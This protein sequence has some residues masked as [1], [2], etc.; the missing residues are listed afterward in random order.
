MSSEDSLFAVIPAIIEYGYVLIR[1]IEKS[2][3]GIVTAS[4]LSLQF[5]Q[6]A[7]PFL[8]LGEI[9]QHIRRLI[10]GKFTKAELEGARNPT[11]DS[12]DRTCCGPQSWRVHQTT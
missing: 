6:L 5:R 1:A 9:E 2:I 11:D 10:E 3:S 12:G 7:E 4:D 8:L